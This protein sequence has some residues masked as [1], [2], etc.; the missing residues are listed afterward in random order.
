MA[1][2]MNDDENCDIDTL[3]DWKKSLNK[4]KND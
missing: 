3:E 4:H 2:V 1:Y